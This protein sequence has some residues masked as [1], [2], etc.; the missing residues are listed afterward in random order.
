MTR[1]HVSLF[2]GIGA[3]DIAAEHLGCGR[4]VRTSRAARTCTRCGGTL[5]LER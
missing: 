3:S 2:S 1:T 4:M 5:V